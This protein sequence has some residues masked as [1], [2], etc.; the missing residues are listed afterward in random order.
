[1]RQ[2]VERNL[3][4]SDRLSFSLADGAD[5]MECAAETVEVDRHGMVFQSRWTFAPCT[6]LE[7]VV[8]VRGR[9]DVCR[10]YAAQGMV[11]ACERKDG[12]YRTAL[13]FIEPLRKTARARKTSRPVSGRG[14]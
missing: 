8:S 11:V 6:V 12:L 10:S 14:C 1:M 4:T 13:H 3:P 2:T 9:N 5:E 7:L